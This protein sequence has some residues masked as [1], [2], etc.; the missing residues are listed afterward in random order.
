MSASNYSPTE[1]VLDGLVSTFERY[2][3]PTPADLVNT[4]VR[5]LSKGGPVRSFT[6][7][8]FTSVARELDGV[9]LRSPQAVASW[10]VTQVAA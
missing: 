1:A 5:C 3:A 4:A 2:E 8:E 6:E 10:L 7:A 9:L